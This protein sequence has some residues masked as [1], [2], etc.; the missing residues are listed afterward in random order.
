[1]GK[2]KKKAKNADGQDDRAGRKMPRKEYE[3]ELAACRASWWPCR[4]G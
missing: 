2:K 3:A 1:M 4:S